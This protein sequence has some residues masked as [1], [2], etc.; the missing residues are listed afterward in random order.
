MHMFDCIC[1]NNCLF[2]SNL[3]LEEEFVDEDVDV[4]GDAKKSYAA[5][6]PPSNEIANPGQIPSEPT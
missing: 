4:E 2:T 3:R 1:L 5:A 6:V